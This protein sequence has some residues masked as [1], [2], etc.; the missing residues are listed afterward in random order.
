MTLK[1]DFEAGMIFISLLTL[2]SESIG[3]VQILCVEIYGGECEFVYKRC[4]SEGG[5]RVRGEPWY[6]SYIIPGS[7]L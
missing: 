7:A 2:Y 4:R 5:V 6:I 1:F 3:S